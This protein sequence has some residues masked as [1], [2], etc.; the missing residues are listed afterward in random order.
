MDKSSIKDLM[1]RWPSRTEFAQDV[2][3]PPSIVHKWFSSDRIPARWQARVVRAAVSRGF[4]DITAEWML[5]VHAEKE[6]K[7]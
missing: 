2:G 5:R 7:Q 3:A 4:S 6:A 1:A